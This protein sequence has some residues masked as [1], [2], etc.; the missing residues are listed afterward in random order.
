MSDLLIGIDGGGTHTRAQ[1][2]DSQ[3]NVLGSGQAGTSNPLAHGLSAAQHELNSAITSAF[4]EANRSP[5]RVAV[6]CMGLGGAGRA[7]EQQELVEWARAE[8]AE[9]VTVVN[10]GQISLAAGTPENWGVA[11]IAGTGSLAWGKHP[12]GHTARAGG[13][14]YLIGDEGSAFDLAQ[15]ALRAAAQYADGRGPATSLLNAIL[16][17]WKLDAPQ[18]IITRVYRSGA[19]HTALAQLAPTVVREAEGGDVVALQITSQAASQLARSVLAVSHSLHF[20]APFPLALTGGLLLGAEFYRALFLR[21]TSALGCACQPIALVH[22]P[23]KGAVRLARELAL[24]VHNHLQE[25][26]PDRES[27]NHETSSTRTNDD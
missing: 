4:R 22:D 17:H 10:D 9:R 8:W 16:R 12:Q 20:G 2:A 1:L 3:G 26:I 19:S 18:E 15:N 5:E 21:A 11:V 23:V 13:W 7:R 6:L 24:N 25:T 27:K 14:G